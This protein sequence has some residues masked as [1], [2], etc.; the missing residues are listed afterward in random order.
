[1]NNPIVWVAVMSISPFV[2]SNVSFYKFVNTDYAI[3]STA[4]ARMEMSEQ[5]CVYKQCI[6]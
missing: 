5:F 4:D 3:S 1:M 6:R 2:F